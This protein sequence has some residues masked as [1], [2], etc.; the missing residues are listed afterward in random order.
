MLHDANED[1][2]IRE[3]RAAREA[4]GARFGYDIAAIVRDA[5]AKDE[6]SGHEV[7]R[8]SPRKVRDMAPI[9]RAR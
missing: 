4:Y 5:K 1:E 7:V 6:A 3:V 2:V 9:R 8:R